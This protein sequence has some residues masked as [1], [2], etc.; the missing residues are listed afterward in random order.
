MPLRL[1]SHNYGTRFT[2]TTCITHSVRNSTRIQIRDL[3]QSSW[4]QIRSIVVNSIVGS[5][6]SLVLLAIPVAGTFSPPC[7]IS[8][9]LHFP[10][11]TTVLRNRSTLRIVETTQRYSCVQRGLVHF[12]RSVR[13]QTQQVLPITAPN[14]PQGG[15]NSRASSNEFSATSWVRYAWH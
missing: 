12:G 6:P 11:H 14:H 1:Q 8:T 3:C 2:G 9:S 10:S 4:L 7:A 13:I 15:V 5:F